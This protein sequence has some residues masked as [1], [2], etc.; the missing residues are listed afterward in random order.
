MSENELTMN[1]KEF[2]KELISN[3]FYYRR[4]LLEKLKDPRRDLYQDC[5]YFESDKL[6]PEIFRDLYERFPIATRVV[7]LP[8]DESWRQQ[9][10]ILETIKSEKETEFEKRWRLLD[11]YIRGEKSWYRDEKGSPV[12]NI[13]KRLDKLSRIGEYGVL[14]F[15]FDDVGK[16]DPA[17]GEVITWRHPAPGFEYTEDEGDFYSSFTFNEHN[18]PIKRNIEGTKLVGLRCFDQAYASVSRWEQNE[19][20]EFY[21]QPLE[22]N[23]TLANNESSSAKEIRGLRERDVKIHWSR[24]L[25]LA[26]MLMN[27]EYIGHSAMKPIVNDLQDLQKMYAASGEGYWRSAFPGLSFESH[28]SMGGKANLDSE[29]IKNQML[30]YQNTL[31]RYIAT[32]G[33]SVKTI[34]GSVSSLG[35]HVDKRIEA[36]CIY[37]GCPVRIFKGSERGQLASGQDKESWDE[38]MFLRQQDHITP[39]IIVPFI[40]RMI[41][42]GVLPEPK[43]GYRVL[44]PDLTV[45]SKTARAD[46][47]SK[48]TEAITKYIAGGLD[49]MISPLDFLVEIWDFDK[50]TAELLLKST[51]DHVNDKNP[52]ADD[53]KTIGEEIQSKDS[54]PPI[55]PLPPNA[56]RMDLGDE[57]DPKGDTPEM[58]EEE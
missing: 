20:S 12:W 13:L 27:S 53:I 44:W 28:P 1:D 3:E 42:V 56:G 46:L 50:E 43:E 23:I 15:E 11:H 4:D 52:E 25:H 16:K 18:R 54:N 8:V 30:A 10:Q 7:D 57:N 48:F 51:I 33:G 45:L 21:G 26:P 37:L 58:E 31:Q 19:N 22:Y 49:A 38:R 29:G 14:V 32:A 24:V 40:D 41:S 9:P 36:I 47:S 17:T 39:N 2:V 6:T 5:G 35:D 34:S 55:G